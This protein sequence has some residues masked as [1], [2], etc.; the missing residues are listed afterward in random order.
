MPTLIQLAK[1]KTVWFSTALSLLGLANSYIGL[2]NLTPDQQNYALTG[3]GAV[4]LFL[5]FITNKAL[6]EK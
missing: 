6:S 2:F 1:S 4:S 3:I 5:R